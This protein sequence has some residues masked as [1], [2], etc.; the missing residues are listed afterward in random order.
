MEWGKLWQGIHDAIEGES[1]LA[2]GKPC[3]YCIQTK[4]IIEFLEKNR[5]LKDDR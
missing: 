1:P 3:R 4:R 5:L 2:K